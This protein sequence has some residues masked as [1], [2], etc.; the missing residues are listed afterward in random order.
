M[1]LGWYALYFAISFAVFIYFTFKGDMHDCDDPGL[2]LIH[3]AWGLLW[4]LWVFLV[5]IA[6]VYGL[7][8]KI[9]RGG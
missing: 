4:P 3:L 1:V 9:V 5:V 7:W 6:W 2:V 8:F